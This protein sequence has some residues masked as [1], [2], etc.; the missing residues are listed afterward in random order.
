MVAA[1]EVAGG[2]RLVSVAG[3]ADVHVGAVIG[4][5]VVTTCTRRNWLLSSS[6]PVKDFARNLLYIIYISFLLDND[7][8]T[9]ITGIATGMS[10]PY[11]ALNCLLQKNDHIFTALDFIFPMLA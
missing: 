8:V 4:H 1:A 10:R 5:L 9:N 11:I 7:S 6:L 2:H 3:E